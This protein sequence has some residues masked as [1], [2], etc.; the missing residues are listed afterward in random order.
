MK[1]PS[2]IVSPG[3]DPRSV[4][5]KEG[6][7]LVPPEDWALLPPGD[8]ALT[9]RVKE[10]GPTWTVQVVKGRKIFSR[11]VWAPRATIDRLARY[12]AAEQATPDYAKKQ[13]ANHERRQR[14]QVAYMEDFHGA[15]VGFLA[16]H[17]RYRPIAERMARTVTLH[18]TPVG[19]G[20]VARTER[21][22]IEERA[23][24][25]VIA[26]MRHQTTGY[27]DMSIARVKGARRE[28]RRELADQSRELLA[29]YRRGDEIDPERCPLWLAL[30]GQR[31]P[32]PEDERD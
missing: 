7:V 2:L 24:A 6:Q 21:I 26:W 16:F 4:R 8:A 20:T 30:I 12:R 17:P 3:P 10:A 28:V 13:A 32:A 27:D 25:A 22:P 19:S 23:R 1:E 14:E 11:G 29:R 31:A 18:A 5:T 9:R 15:V